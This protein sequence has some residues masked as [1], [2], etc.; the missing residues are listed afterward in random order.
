ML[1]EQLEYNFISIGNKTR[2]YAERLGMSIVEFQKFCLKNPETDQ[3]IDYSFSRECNNSEKLI[4][5][6][7]LGFKFIENAFHILLQISEERAIQRL[8]K[9]K[10]DNES[11]ET[12]RE[13]NN[14][15][16]KQFESNYR[17]DFTEPKNYDLVI[18]VEDFDSPQQIVSFILSQFS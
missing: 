18:N 3:Q 7:R 8:T 2:E 6:Y 9:A 14:A 12:L 13:R 1:A 11:H 16:K 10:R 17:V 5:D 15:F 4:I